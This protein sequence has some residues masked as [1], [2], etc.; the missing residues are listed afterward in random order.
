MN[1]VGYV[2]DPAGGKYGVA[3]DW[4]LVQYPLGYRKP[5][6]GRKSTKVTATYVE[7][8]EQTVSD[9][10]RRSELRPAMVG[11]TDCPKCL[12]LRKHGKPS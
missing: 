5:G 2:R 10:I 6:T 3:H 11:D 12:L 8:C 4:R 1:L 7:K 9:I